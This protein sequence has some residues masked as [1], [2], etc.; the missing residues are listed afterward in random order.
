MGFWSQASGLRGA[1]TP[2][3][4]S[5][6]PLVHWQRNELRCLHEGPRVTPGASAYVSVENQCR[7]CARWGRE[8]TPRCAGRGK[9]AVDR[10][11]R[12]WKPDTL[13]AWGPD[14]EVA[15]PEVQR[16]RALQSL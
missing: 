5:P 9:R 11:R 14:E 15:A 6:L 1:R 2:H 16:D 8:A 7:D 10:I 4:V 12:E 13:L 3:K